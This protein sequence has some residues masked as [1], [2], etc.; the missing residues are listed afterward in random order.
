MFATELIQVIRVK[1]LIFILFTAAITSLFFYLAEYFL[2]PVPLLIVSLFFLTV[3]MNLVVYMLRRFG[4]ATIFMFIT[5]MLTFDLAEIGLFGWNKVITYVIAAIVFE[6]IY[7]IFKIEVAS[8]PLDM[9]FGT[10]VS[11]A[12][13]FLISAILL[14]QTIILVFTSELFNLLILSFGISLISAIVFAIIWGK[15]A[16]T[17]S[18][19]KF[20]AFLA[21]LS[22]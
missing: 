11:L 22:K 18:I 19:V 17:N 16:T 15:I 4:V 9:I 5:A 6:I 10:A 21:S 8:L 14:S 3:G 20:E 2:P 12:S 1:Q 13:I 7:L